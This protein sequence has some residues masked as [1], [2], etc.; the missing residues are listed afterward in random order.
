[1]IGNPKQPKKKKKSNVIPEKIRKEVFERD[2]G[3]C[4]YCGRLTDALDKTA[5]FLSSAHCHHVKHKS[6]GG[7]NIPEDLNTCCFECHFCHGEISAT[8]KRWLDGED[9]YINGRMVKHG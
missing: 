2:G 8:D 7:K 3:I 4:Q 6:Q 9:V 1:M 5:Y